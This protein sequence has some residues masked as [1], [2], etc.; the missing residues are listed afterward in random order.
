MKYRWMFFDVGSTL[1]DE[2]EAYDHRV[3][4]M[5]AGTELTF[6]QFDEKRIEFAKQGLDGNSSAIRFF[7]LQKTPWHSEDELPYK[8]AEQTLRYL[9]AAGFHLGIIANQS[10]GTDER[11]KKWG[12]RSF[13][14][15][16]AASAEVGYAK[17]DE[18]IFRTALA[19][20]GC[21]PE[22]AVMI[23]DR[24]DND[25]RPAKL[26]GMKTVWIR[27]GLSRYQERSLGK[28]Y[29]DYIIDELTELCSLF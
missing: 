19:Q 27:K 23:G 8:D 26:L 9:K 4:E 28:P 12:L 6:E 3:H 13:F 18:R 21:E 2:R 15:V 7:A 5:I 11:L 29:A 10:P 14:E 24:L 20:A 22:E 1:V 25:I 17:P 16:I